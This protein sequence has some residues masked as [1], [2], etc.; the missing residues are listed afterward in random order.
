MQLSST[1]SVSVIA[2]LKTIFARHG[3]PI[4]RSEVTT[5]RNS[6]QWPYL[7]EFKQKNAQ[8]QAG[9]KAQFDRRHLVK[10]LVPIPDD[11]EVWITSE[12]QP[13]PGRVVSTGYTPRSYVVATESGPLRRNRGQINVVPEP[14][15]NESN[16]SSESS[17]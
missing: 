13:I 8:F 9:Q 6:R 14:T 11:S 7:V 4:R 5:G 17:E 12:G 10:E 2:A 15:S 1:T 3:I 16:E